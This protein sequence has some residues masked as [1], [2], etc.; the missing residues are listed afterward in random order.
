MS[1]ESAKEIIE[2]E[3]NAMDFND[4]YD[5]ILDDDRLAPLKRNQACLQC[6]KRKVKCDGVS[7]YVP[8]LFHIQ[9]IILVKLS[10]YH[11]S[12]L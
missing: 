3:D 4:P 8:E 6:K 7:Q 5:D 9:P 1:Q 11:S 12:S 2:R 10:F